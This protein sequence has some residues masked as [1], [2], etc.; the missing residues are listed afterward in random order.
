MTNNEYMD[1]E[2]NTLCCCVVPN[3][4]RNNLHSPMLS[5]IDVP[6]YLFSYIFF[7]FYLDGMKSVSKNVTTDKMY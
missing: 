3:N 6:L 1:D 4:N 2:N 7:F 5:C